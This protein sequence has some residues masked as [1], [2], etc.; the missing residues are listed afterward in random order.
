MRPFLAEFVGTFALV[1]AGTGAI[2]VNDVSRG[3]VTHVGVSLTFGL[4]V[5]A[6]IYALGNVSGAQINPAVTLALAAAKKFPARSVLP[7][8]AAQVAGALAASGLLRLLFPAHAGLGATLPAGEAWQ[9][10]VLE[11]VMTWLLMLTIFGVA[12]QKIAGVV[13]GGVVAL[14]A[15]FGGPV[16]GASMNP[17]RSLA[18][19][20]VS[21]RLEHLWIYLAATT[22]GALLAAPVAG[23]LY[24]GKRGRT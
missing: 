19:A 16:S 23:H 17:A 21:G 24:G 12:G 2:V 13:V 3:V 10:F 11:L 14:E 1:F 5:M 6:M 9:S 4:V 18:P 7:Y 22:L 15:L 8:F 20:L